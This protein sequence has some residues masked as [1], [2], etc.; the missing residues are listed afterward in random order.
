MKNN[1]SGRLHSAE[2][3]SPWCGGI[4]IHLLCGL[5]AEFGLS[6]DFFFWGFYIFL[7]IVFETGLRGAKNFLVS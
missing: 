7:A 4:G 1:A 5:G 2:R 3:S 6:A